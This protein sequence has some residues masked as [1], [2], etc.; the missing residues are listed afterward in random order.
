MPARPRARLSALAVIIVLSFGLAVPL[1]APAPARAL[2]LPPG[3]SES[4]VFSGLTNPTVVKFASD[5]R[6]FVGE[7]SGLVKVFDSLVDPTPDVFVDLR[8]SV[9]N[10]WDRGLLGMALAPDFP[11]DPSVYVL[12][13]YDAV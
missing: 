9:H 6:V 3:F 2:T 10:F 7:K 4:I 13:T 8:T 12:Y 1:A 11:T 5:G